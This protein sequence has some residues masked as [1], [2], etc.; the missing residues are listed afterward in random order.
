MYITG[1]NPSEKLRF[2][3]NLQPFVRPLDK[4]PGS[5]L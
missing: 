3:G 5:L 4:L 1:Q 2:L